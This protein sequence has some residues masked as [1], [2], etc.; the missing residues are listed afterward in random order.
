MI[1]R[2]KIEGKEVVLVGTAHISKESITLVE[3]TIEEEK[4]D[5]LGVELDKDRLY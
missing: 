5:A 1:K 4:P 3:K 2:I